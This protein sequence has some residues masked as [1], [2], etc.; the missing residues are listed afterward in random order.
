[1][2]KL[3]LAT[4]LLVAGCGTALPPAPKTFRQALVESA[5]TYSSTA[6]LAISYA[7][8]PHCG[9]SKAPPAPLCSDPAAVVVIGQA[10]AVAQAALHAA[11]ALDGVNDPAAQDKALAAITA[12]LS[13]FESLTN[14]A[15]GK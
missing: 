6:A 8:Q 3:I 10:S 11:Q 1:M 9:A 2:R 7:Q 15:K 5:V 14:A 4:A 13:D 12:A